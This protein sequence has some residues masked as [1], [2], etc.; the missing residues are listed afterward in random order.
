M[1]EE[2]G[3]GDLG[4]IAGQHLA[5]ARI[6]HMQLSQSRSLG[7][8]IILPSRARERDVVGKTVPENMGAAEKRLEQLRQPGISPA[9]RALA[10]PDSGRLK[11]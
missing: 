9:A 7:G 4:L 1:K 8:I 11:P 10:V 2:H 6:L 3:Q 5:R